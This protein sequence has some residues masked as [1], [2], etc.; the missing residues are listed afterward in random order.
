MTMGQILLTDVAAG[1]LRTDDAPHLTFSLCI[2]GGRLD[3]AVID[4]AGSANVFPGGSWI[5]LL[6]QIIDVV[7]MLTHDWHAFLISFIGL[8]V[9]SLISLLG[10]LL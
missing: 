8:N 2:N 7:E 6:R 3:N 1:G 4:F 9:F 5:G 10:Y